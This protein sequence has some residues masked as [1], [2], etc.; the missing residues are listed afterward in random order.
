MPAY[1]NCH[2]RPDHSW[3]AG[4]LTELHN[5]TLPSPSPPPPQP[6]TPC[7][8]DRPIV[9]TRAFVSSRPAGVVFTPRQ[10]RAAAPQASLSP[11]PHAH[12]RGPAPSP[13]RRRSPRRHR[14]ATLGDECWLRQLGAPHVDR[15]L[16]EQPPARR[17][18]SASRSTSLISHPSLAAVVS[19]SLRAGVL[20]SGLRFFLPRRRELR[21]PQLPAS[22]RVAARAG[23]LTPAPR[24][25]P[26]GPARLV[27]TATKD[28]RPRRSK[29]PAALG[30]A[31]AAAA[32]AAVIL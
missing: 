5:T 27:P 14:R 2:P 25:L 10:T 3:P 16:S 29:T 32:A 8:H 19:S 1:C 6:A 23:T 21:A 24:L 28:S 12:R 30:N 4:S 15:N 11:R 31:L 18:T 26:S 17:R 13:H 7:G 9:T 22:S 20:R